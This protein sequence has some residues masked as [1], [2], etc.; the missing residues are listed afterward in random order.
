TYRTAQTASTRSVRSALRRCRARR[1][2]CDLSSRTTLTESRPLA[3]THRITR[4]WLALGAKVTTT[5]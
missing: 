3:R 2:T 5:R 4:P 1:A